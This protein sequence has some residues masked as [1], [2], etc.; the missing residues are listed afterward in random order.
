M[1]VK[2]TSILGLVVVVV[3]C[4]S[5]E[6]KVQ[7]E[8]IKTWADQGIVAASGDLAHGSQ[9]G[10]EAQSTEDKTLGLLGTQEDKE[11]SE[12]H[13]VAEKEQVDDG[14]A[15]IA[16]EQQSW[17]EEGLV[18][19][20]NYEENVSNEESADW[21]NEADYVIA[22]VAGWAQAP[23]HLAEE[24]SADLSIEV[25]ETAQA[26]SAES[27]SIEETIQR[28]PAHAGAQDAGLGS[29]TDTCSATL[30]EEPRRDDSH[31][32][33]NQSAG[34][35]TWWNTVM[36]IGIDET[37]DAWQGQLNKNE[38]WRSSLYPKGWQPGY[39]IY[40][41]QGQKELFLQDYS[42]AGYHQGHQSLPVPQANDTIFDVTTYGAD[43]SGSNDSWAAVQKA[44]IAAEQANH[45]VVYFPAGHYLIEGSASA[46]DDLKDELNLLPNPPSSTRLNALDHGILRV[47]DSYVTLRGAGEHLS[48]L[49]FPRS[50]GM[51]EWS[52]QAHIL[53]EPVGTWGHGASSHA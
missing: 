9:E 41:D 15:L 31:G 23:E 10:K 28:T 21:E 49:Y 37:P 18:P 7:N 45:G 27:L 11:N 8:E 3:A 14:D 51:S 50:E 48:H 38:F 33:N 42:Y 22:Q 43:A 6:P 34:L 26:A 36:A 25:S 2:Y 32:S 35:T 47:A 44:I 20:K 52:R 17:V 19:E 4:G 1:F 40:S 53:F 24:V 39:K 29:C 13:V 30:A 46:L 12:E 5:Q 16:A